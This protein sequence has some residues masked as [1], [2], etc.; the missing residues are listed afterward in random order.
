MLVSLGAPA[1]QGHGVGAGAGVP[2]GL[3]DF[4]PEE[5]P[6]I[7]SPWMASGWMSIRSPWPSF[8]AL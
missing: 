8:A 2:D 3:R 7:G 4:Y 5:G 6:V 1:G